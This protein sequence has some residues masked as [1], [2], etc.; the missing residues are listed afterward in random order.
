MSNQHNLK[1]IGLKSRGLYPPQVAGVQDKLP[2]N[3]ASIAKI[4]G[5]E[6]INM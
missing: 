6:D 5:L 3:Y 2:S 4:A 1:G